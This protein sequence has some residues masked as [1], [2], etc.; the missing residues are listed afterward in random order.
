MALTDSQNKPSEADALP[1]VAKV[2]SFPSCEKSLRFCSSFNLRYRT[3]A[4]ASPT[5]R[6]FVRQSGDVA[7]DV[8]HVY[9]RTPPAVGIQIP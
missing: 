7:C 5:V 6:A 4:Y 1:M 2:I 9:L 8:V 3:D